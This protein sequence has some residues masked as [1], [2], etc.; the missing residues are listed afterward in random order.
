[1]SH[2]YFHDLSLKRQG[3]TG[4]CEAQ[5]E[6]PFELWLP[7]SLIHLGLGLAAI[8]VAIIS[9]MYVAQTWLLFPTTL[10]AARN[11]QLPASAQRLE[12]STPD[13]ELL[14][15]THIPA[16]SNRAECGPTL[17]GF[18]GNAW[19]ADAM[20]LYLHGLF[21]D[22]D[23]VAFHYRGYY[24]SSGRPSAQK[25]LEDSLVI[26][27]TL[28]AGM[29]PERVVAVG[30]SVGSTVAA[31]VARYRP[32]AGLIMV[33]PFD[34]LETLAQDLYWWAP[35]RL[36]L[37]HRM[38]TID[39]VRGSTTPTTLIVAEHDSIVPARRSEPLRT[40]ITNL[41]LDRTIEA[42]HNDL[43]DQPAFADAVRQALAKIV[44]SP[45]PASQ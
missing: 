22:C 8:Y 43:Y 34:S 19:N 45:K 26:F 24:P 40:A 5:T 42:G 3:Y 9:G 38:P 2:G 13:G 44:G 39:F 21:P 1:M 15:G 27:D 32:V 20:A 28:Q 25:L 11:V 29:L 14:I 33:T 4:A 7:V 10:A 18:G 41:V 36:L 31:Y 30:F 16:R 17:L 23:V 37:R 12:V 6:R 35:V